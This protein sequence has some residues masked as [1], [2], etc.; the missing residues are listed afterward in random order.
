MFIWFSSH[1][2]ILNILSTAHYLLRSCTINRLN[3]TIKWFY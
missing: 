2:E 3:I 1:L